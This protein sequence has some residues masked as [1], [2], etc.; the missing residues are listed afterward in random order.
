MKSDLTTE[1]KVLAFFYRCRFTIENALI[2]SW[3][4]I[5]HFHPHAFHKP[6]V[7]VIELKIKDHFCM[8][9]ASKALSLA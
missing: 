7:T 4:D 9:I 8:I 6:F 2:V 3:A 5:S 1:P